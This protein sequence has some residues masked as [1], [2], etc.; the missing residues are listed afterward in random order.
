MLLLVTLMAVLGHLHHPDEAFAKVLGQHRLAL[1]KVATDVEDDEPLML[2]HH[3]GNLVDDPLGIRGPVTIEGQY[4]VVLLCPGQGRSVHGL[5][6]GQ[7]GADPPHLVEHL[8]EV[9]S[10]GQQMG[11]QQ[12]AEIP[13]ASLFGEMAKKQMLRSL[14]VQLWPP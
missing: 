2:P 4:G 6:F 1:G 14:T 7:D 10:V 9:G 12:D 3:G 13:E 8:D 5:G 11:H